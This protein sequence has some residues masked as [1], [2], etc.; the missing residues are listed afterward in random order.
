MKWIITIWDRKTGTIAALERT[1]GEDTDKDVVRHLGG[2][3]NLYTACTSTRV[4]REYMQAGTTKDGSKAF[5]ILCVE[6]N[7][8]QDVV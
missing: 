4:A 8:Q 1:S 5:S 2:W 6:D 7:P 3:D